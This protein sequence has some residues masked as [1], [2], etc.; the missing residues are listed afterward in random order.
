V[1]HTISKWSTLD[2]QYKSLHQR[3]RLKLE[4]KIAKVSAPAPDGSSDPD[5]A[6]HH[7]QALESQAVVG[8][9]SSAREMERRLNQQRGAYMS[10]LR[11]PQ[12][13]EKILVRPEQKNIV[14]RAPPEKRAPFQL[15]MK[16]FMNG[17]T[18]LSSAGGAQVSPEAMNGIQAAAPAVEGG[19]AAPSAPMP[20]MVF[21]SESVDV[22]TQ[23][24]K[25]TS[26]LADKLFPEAPGKAS[27]ASHSTRNGGM[28]ASP[29]KNSG[30][31]R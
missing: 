14:N 5:A 29:G 19:A 3:E 6:P 8:E 20:T 12:I 31:V 30:G 25:S 1:K 26:S 18:E 21:G 2:F 9:G 24:P 15:N 4:K 10:K 23:K 13:R 17:E 22:E 16:R 27:A 7:Q 28:G 11:P